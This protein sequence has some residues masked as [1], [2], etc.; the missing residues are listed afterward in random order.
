MDLGKRFLRISGV[1]RRSVTGDAVRGP[2]P[3]RRKTAFG[4]PTWHFAPYTSSMVGWRWWSSPGMGRVRPP[5][6]PFATL[7]RSNR[8]SPECLSLFVWFFTGSRGISVSLKRHAGDSPPGRVYRF[9]ASGWIP[10]RSVRSRDHTLHRGVQRPLHAGGFNASNS[11]RKASE[12][13]FVPRNSMK[14]RSFLPAMPSSAIILPRE[15]LRGTAGSR[16]KQVAALGRLGKCGEVE[17]CQRGV[18]T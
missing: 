1:T 4:N 8:P 13:V 16:E 18:R 17:M 6:A 12:S 5:A 2:G 15:V 10:E 9:V 7:P 3:Q 14:N 11:R